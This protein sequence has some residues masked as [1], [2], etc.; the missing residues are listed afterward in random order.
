M[1]VKISNEEIDIQ[2]NMA[3]EI[4]YEEVAGEPFNIESLSKMKNTMA[5]CMAAIVAANPDTSITM[6][7]LLK[8]ASVKEIGEL[9]NAVTETMMEW[10]Q[11][12]KVIADAEAKEEQPDVNEEQPKN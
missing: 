2:F 9:K 3:V 10:L 7:Y 11:I 8:N 12:P 1:K 5:L 4:A 6:E